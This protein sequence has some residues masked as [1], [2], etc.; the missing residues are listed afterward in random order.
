MSTDFSTPRPFTSAPTDWQLWL[1][2]LSTILVGLVL[3]RLMPAGFAREIAGSATA[4]LS[5]IV[6][7]PLV[8]EIL[9]R[10]VI[11]R[12]LLTR[13]IWRRRISGLSLANLGTSVLFMLAHMANQG[14]FWGVSVLA[15]SLVLGHFRER[16]DSILPSILLHFLFNLC[17]LFAGL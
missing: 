2:F 12:E 17:Y 6:F 14:L 3:W 9:F 4:I 5:F 7:Y 11:Q 8:E 13:D 10:G 1:V 15:P 16:Y